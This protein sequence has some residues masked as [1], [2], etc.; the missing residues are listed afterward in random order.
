MSRKTDSRS[1]FTLIE[2]IAVA[3]IVGVLVTLIGILVQRVGERNRCSLARAQIEQIQD[4]LQDHRV[5]QGELP[6]TLVE[7]AAR[8]P[9]GFAFATNGLPVDPWS[10]PYAYSL[11][12]ERFDLRSIGPDAATDTADDIVAGRY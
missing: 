6:A 7:V 1:G 12:G 8:L 2:L 10:Q 3:A 4:A 11:N 5:R 9:R